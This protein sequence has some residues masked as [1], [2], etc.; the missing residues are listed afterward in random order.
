VEE[1]CEQRGGW[2]V[3]GVGEEVRVR[4]GREGR[5]SKQT[6]DRVREE[7]RRE[8]GRRDGESGWRERRGGGGKDKGDGA[9]WVGKGALGWGASTIR[10]DVHLGEDASS[11]RPTP[12]S[13]RACWRPVP[14]D[15]LMCVS[16]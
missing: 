9:G 5:D 2:G 14:S 13:G 10:S 6:V 4:E 8:G 12:L 3:G 11:I 15:S 1:A 16:D 7:G